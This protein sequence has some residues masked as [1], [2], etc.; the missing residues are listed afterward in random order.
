MSESVNFIQGRK[1][2]YNPSEMQGGLFFSKDSKEILLNGESYGNATPADEEDITAEDGNLKLKDRAYDEAS[3]SGKGYKILRKNIVEGKNI[4]TQDMI[5]KPNTIYEIRYDFDL[6]GATISIPD[7]SLLK[8]NKGFIDNGV[9]EGNYSSILSEPIQIF[10]QSLKLEKNWRLRNIYPEWFGAIADGVTDCTS[11]LQNCINQLDNNYGGVVKLQQGIYVCNG[12]SLKV[13]TSIEGVARG[14][15]ILQKK[16]ETDTPII[17]CPTESFGI[18]IRHLTIVGNKKLADGI[19]IQRSGNG[20]HREYMDK[21]LTSND[22]VD[23]PSYFISNIEDVKVTQCKYAIY[24]SSGSFYTHIYNCLFGESIYGV[25]FGTTDSDISY[26]YINNHQNYGIEIAGGNNK[27]S[28]LKVIFCNWGYTSDDT[29]LY[30]VKVTG[31]RN[32]ITSVETQDNSCGGFYVGGSSNTLIGCI[33]NTDGYGNNDGLKIYDESLNPI[34]YYIASSS[35]IIKECV[36]TGYNTKYG[37]IMQSPVKVDSQLGNYDDFDIT[38]QLRPVGSGQWFSQEAIREIRQSIPNKNTNIISNFQIEPITDYY[39]PEYSD[40]EFKVFSG[41]PVIDL[42][43]INSNSFTILNSI[44]LNNNKSIY[45]RGFHIPSLQIQSVLVQSS[46][47][48]NIRV[49]LVKD[50]NNENIKSIYIPSNI[51]ENA[52]PGDIIRYAIGIQYSGQNTYQMKMQL[53]YIP[54]AFV[55]NDSEQLLSRIYY[56][57]VYFTFQHEEVN[58][59]SIEFNLP[60]AQQQNRNYSHEFGVFNGFLN[61][62]ILYPNLYPVRLYNKAL[63]YINANNKYPII[64]SRGEENGRPTLDSRNIGFQY[65]DTTIKKPVYWNGTEWITSEGLD[66][67]S[68]GWAVIE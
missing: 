60:S 51:V 67:N 38:V 59:S 39:Y 53:Y 49:E 31:S 4:L 66:A 63:V 43:S 28:N 65:F 11:I 9:L 58:I 25:Y 68:T 6:N 56:D 40:Q 12:I 5:N 14:V 32:S 22:I 62:S 21:L 61:S 30:A 19:H 13:K 2:Q 26:C 37:T 41:N 3:F 20:E 8:F 33:S 55:Y 50:N 23:W 35:N 27:V 16:D 24:V 44:I 29:T 17:N 54:K 34:C 1:E 52:S 47:S 42:S 46:S 57:E 7:N 15:S 45:P 18:S 36:A 64:S 10:G 48:N